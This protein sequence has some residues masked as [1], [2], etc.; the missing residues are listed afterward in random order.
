[1]FSCNVLTH[2]QAVPGKAK[3]QI[4]ARR[5]AFK[6]QKHNA[7][8]KAKS[9]LEGTEK[10]TAKNLLSAVDAANAAKRSN[11]KVQKKGQQDP[12]P[13]WRC[14]EAGGS[15]CSR[16]SSKPSLGKSQAMRMGAAAV[17]APGTTK[18]R[19]AIV[20]Q[21]QPAV[22]KLV[23]QTHQQQQQVDS[24]LRSVDKQLANRGTK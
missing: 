17:L 18:E 23:K 7:H 20:K 4:S 5:Q 3:R 15:I 10:A 2:A 21:A 19:L 14:A 16:S 13:S 11:N 8:K 9:Q 1:V 6:K 24:V 22:A 12:G